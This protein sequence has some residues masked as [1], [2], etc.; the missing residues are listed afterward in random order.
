M[1]TKEAI[2]GFVKKYKMET[3]AVFAWSF[4]S[5]YLFELKIAKI[6]NLCYEALSI[7]LFL[8]LGSFLIDK[9]FIIYEEEI[10]KKIVERYSISDNK[11]ENTIFNILKSVAYLIVT[12]CG[13][14][15]YRLSIYLMTKHEVIKKSNYSSYAHKSIIIMKNYSLI[16]VCVLLVVFVF[17]FVMKEK[18]IDIKNFSLKVFINFLFLFLVECV[19]LIG[20]LVLYLICEALL[21]TIS[22]S[23]ISRIITFIISVV[24]LMGLLVGLESVKGENSLFSKILVRYIMQTMVFIGFIIFYVYLIKIIIKMELPSNQ[25]FSVCTTLFS[26]GLFTSLMSL[27]ID[28]E[29]VYSK[30]IKYL[31]IAFMP[32]LIMQIISISLRVNQH[33]MTISRYFGVMV[34]I[35]EIV[36]LVFYILDEIL[37][38]E[39]VKLKNILIIS[40]ILILIMFFIPKV[41][42]YEFSDIYNKSFKK[43]QKTEVVVNSNRYEKDTHVIGSTTFDDIEV[44]IREYDKL[45]TFNIYVQ[46]DKNGKKYFSIEETIKEKKEYDNNTIDISNIINNLENNIKSIDVNNYHPEDLFKDIGY[47]IVTGSNKM[48]IN[49]IW[50]DYD[51]EIEKVINLELTGYIVTKDD[52]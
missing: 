21:G 18:K 16:I 50:M 10:K 19:V 8:I 46:Y 31:P 28:E 25:I 4:V 17:Y 26:I 35:F 3:I 5:A 36:Y 44:D 41:N 29:S 9:I 23:I 42:S 48:I 2:I 39:K 51:K 34:I 38:N 6:E 13:Y 43:S 52:K 47:E 33:G 12:I 7:L 40:N 14:I 32:A 49:K 24:S 15:I 45:R 37:K 27:A 30:A 11:K 20:I 22:Y 1:K